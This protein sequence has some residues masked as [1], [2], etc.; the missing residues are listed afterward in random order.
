MGSVKWFLGMHFKWLATKDIVLVHLSQTS[1][2]THLVKDNNIHTRNITLD[3]T[4]YCSSLPINAIPESNEPNGCPALIKRKCKYQS[5]VGLIRWLAQSTCSN[6]SPMHSFLSAY[7]NKPSRSHWNAALYALHYIHSTIDYGFTFTLQAW[8]QLYTYMSFPPASNTKAY[9]NAMPPCK[10][11]HHC[12]TTYSNA[13]WGSQL[14]NAVRKGIQIPLFKLCCMSGAI[15]MCSGS[16]IFW[17]P[18]RQEHMCLSSC[19]AE[20]CATNMGSRLTVNNCYMIKHLS[21]LGCPVTNATHPT[22]LYNDNNTCVKWC[23]NMTTKGNSHIKNCKNATQEWVADSTIAIEHVLGKSSVATIFTKE[24]HNRANF[25]CLCDS[26]MC[27]SGDYLHGAHNIAQ[28]SSSPPLD[29]VPPSSLSPTSHVPVLAQS[30]ACAH[31][32]HPGIFDVLISYPSLRL[33]L[34][35]ATISAKGCHIL[36]CHAP[37]FYMQVLLSNPMGGVST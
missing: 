8:D 33:P 17:E 35:L 19:E 27:H 12:L 7:C 22:V 3:A 15:V 34:M 1:F 5:V 25:H 9:T 28:L 37:P 18:E 23:H 14:G 13:C 29:V 36:S 20:T 10:H 2:A 32:L 6:L 16:P 31:P 11:K 26:F 24:I 21:S 30:T 4:P